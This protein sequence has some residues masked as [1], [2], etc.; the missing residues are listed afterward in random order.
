MKRN[1]AVM[2]AN[3]AIIINDDDSVQYLAEHV[4]EHAAQGGSMFGVGSF[5]C[6]T[7]E[8]LMESLNLKLTRDIDTVID[9]TKQKLKEEEDS[10]EVSE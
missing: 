9:M 3:I 4:G 5:K 8:G 6:D 2:I 10:E 1:P 7:L